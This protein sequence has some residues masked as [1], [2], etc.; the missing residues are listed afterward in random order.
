MIM[1]IYKNTIE[2]ESEN[3]WARYARPSGAPG[4]FKGE[5]HHLEGEWGGILN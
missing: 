1:S 4:F 5:D 3:G 2:C